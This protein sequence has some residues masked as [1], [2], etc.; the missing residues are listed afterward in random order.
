MQRIQVSREQH[1]PNDYIEAITLGVEIAPQLLSKLRSAATLI[2]SEPKIED[3]KSIGFQNRE[4][5]SNSE[6]TL[7]LRIWL[8]IKNSRKPL[9]SKGKPN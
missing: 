8:M 7:M 1:N 9:I 5:K 6:I 3:F 4:N 2:D